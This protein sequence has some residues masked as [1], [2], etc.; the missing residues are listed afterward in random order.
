MFA[1]SHSVPVEYPARIAALPGYHIN[2]TPGP[3]A[4]IE[5]ELSVPRA[6][7][8][9]VLVWS[10]LPA[11]VS[12]PAANPPFASRWTSVL[13]VFAVVPPA[14]AAAA[15]AQVVPLKVS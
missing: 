12:A 14:A 10:I 9:A 7:R 1:S 6:T 5:P 8:P 13:G 2:R 3:V 11:S 4:G 15:G